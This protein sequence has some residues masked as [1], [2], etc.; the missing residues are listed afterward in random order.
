MISLNATLIV[1]LINL[2]VLIFILNRLMYRPIKRIA[3][4][5]AAKVAAGHAEAAELEERNREAEAAYRRES[6]QRRSQV[7]SRLEELRQ[8]AEAEAMAIVSEAQEEARERQAAMGVRVSEELERAR[9]EIREEAEK[10]A[11]SLAWS[12]LGREVS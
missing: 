3:A 10:V 12:V 9:A 8:K 2:L 1:Q 6:I 5:R 4:E 11:R 7:R